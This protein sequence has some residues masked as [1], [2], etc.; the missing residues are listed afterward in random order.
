MNLYARYMFVCVNEF[1]WLKWNSS[2]VFIWPG[3]HSPYTHFQTIDILLS[4]LLIVH[5]ATSFRFIF[6]SFLLLSFNKLNCWW[7]HFWF[8]MLFVRYRTQINCFS[9]LTHNELNVMHLKCVNKT[10][11]ANNKHFV[12]RIIL[13]IMVIHF[14]T[15]LHLSIWFDW[16][17]AHK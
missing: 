12:Y 7:L 11:E 3:H 8:L 4:S 2:L 9:C 15:F 16:I 6:C 17:L 5:F 1:N 13:H 10:A 14:S